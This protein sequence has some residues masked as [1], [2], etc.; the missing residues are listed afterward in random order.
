MTT[1]NIKWDQKFITCDTNEKTEEILKKHFWSLDIPKKGAWRQ[2][3]RE[4]LRIIE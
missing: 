1:V 2:D 4:Y 3:G